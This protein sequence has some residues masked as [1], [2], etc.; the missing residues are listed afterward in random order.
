MRVLAVWAVL[1]AVY[2]ATLGVDALGKGD[3]AGDEPRH[4]LAAESI[5]SDR[6]IDLRDEFA[7]RAYAEFHPGEL[8]ARGDGRARAAARAAGLR[9]RAPHRACVLRS[10]ARRASS[11]SSPRWRRWPSRSARCSRAGSCPSRRRRAGAL[12][13]GLSPPA[14]AHSTTV[15][16][17]L[18]AGAMLAGATLA[19]LRVRERPDL[20]SAVV[21]AALLALLPWLGPKFLLPAA[22]VAV[23]LVRWTARRGRRTAALAAAE[24]M[25]ASLVV[26][27]TINDRLYGGLVPSAV[28]ASGE[29]A[30]GASS[31]GDY[32]ERVPRLAALW[33]D[34]D[35]G[36]LRWAPVLALAVFAAWLLFRSRRTHVA[37]VAADRGDAEVA[38]GLCLLV[39]GARRARGGV[40]GADA[41]RRLVP[42]TPPHG[43]VPGG[44]GV[45]RVGAAA[46]ASDWGG[47]G[48][49]DA[50]LLGLAGGGPGD[51]ER[52]RVGAAGGGCAV[53][54]GGGVASAVCGALANVNGG[55]VGI[56]FEPPR[57]G[58]YAIDRAYRGRLH[59]RAARSASRHFPPIRWKS[60]TRPGRT[61]ALPSQPLTFAALAADAYRAASC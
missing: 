30:T 21:G 56:G 38:A 49:S 44:R 59:T 33:I 29:P 32:L 14:L 35:A 48:R 46:R 15:S 58:E 6:D 10:A 9:L 31:V 16:P 18:A 52:R 40:R 37:R 28:A 24:I 22:P 26:Y 42:G 60:R 53:R 13:V 54:A 36:L 20:T 23:A 12:L 2:A 8:R 50:A 34:R 4:L 17:D 7:T 25:V 11:S 57:Q 39:C 3:F 43:R 45:G 41:D 61:P 1:F 51:R 19:A 5:V 47:A 27:A 55:W